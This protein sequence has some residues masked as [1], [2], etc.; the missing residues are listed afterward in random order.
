MSIANFRKLWHPRRPTPLDAVP[1][2]PVAD[3]TKHPGFR[4]P[5][6]P[7][8]CRASARPSWQV[9]EE[10]E[11]YIPDLL[12]DDDYEPD[13]ALS[14]AADAHT[15][16]QREAMALLDDAENLLG[17]ARLDRIRV[18]QPGDAGRSGA[19]DREEET[20]EGVRIDRQEGDRR[21]LFLA[22]FEM[23]ARFGKDRE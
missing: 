5:S 19:E 1:V 18:R 7:S 2:R 11:Y 20:Q 14:D 23:K 13:P 4:D 17:A 12:T 9:R 21:N 22:T 3:L 10:F 6:S 15:E 16:A 8:T